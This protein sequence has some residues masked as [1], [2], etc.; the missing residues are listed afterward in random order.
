MTQQTHKRDL[1][2]STDYG[3]PWEADA[4]T[5]PEPNIQPEKNYLDGFGELVFGKSLRWYKEVAAWPMFILLLLEIGLRVMQT[6]YFITIEPEIFTSLINFSRLS[7]FVYLTVSGVKR[8]LANKKQI[9][10]A[11]VLGGL[12]AGVILGLFQLFWYRD[13]WTVFNLIGQP[14]LLAAEGLVISWLV[15]RLF[16]AKSK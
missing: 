9:L 11:A 1:Q 15:Y 2:Y 5:V 12:L 14:L 16:F 4:K 13:L 8:Y 3:H 6:K 7:A 10:T